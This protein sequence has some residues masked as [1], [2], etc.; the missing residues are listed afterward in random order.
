MW[1]KK[2]V[3]LVVAELETKVQVH[4]V[5]G[6][7]E[8]TALK[9]QIKSCFETGFC[10]SRDLDWVCLLCQVKIKRQGKS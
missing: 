1:A 4:Q 9:A 5:W 2:Q 8:L 10:Y 3:D 7:L 6:Q